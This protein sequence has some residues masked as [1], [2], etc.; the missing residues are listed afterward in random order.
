MSH[1]TKLT[2]AAQLLGSKGGFARAKTMSSEERREGAKKAA[3]ARWAKV[4]LERASEASQWKWPPL[5]E[6]RQ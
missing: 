1:I 5:K 4:R 3:N 6:E 2:R